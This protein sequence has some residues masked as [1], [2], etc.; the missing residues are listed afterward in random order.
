MEHAP[1]AI[2]LNGLL[3][4]LNELRHCAPQSL[5]GAAAEALQVSLVAAGGALGAAGTARALG[6]AERP[7]LAAACAA[8]TGTLVPYAAACFDRVYAGGGAL[9]NAKA[10]AAA[11]TGENGAA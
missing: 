9:L 3:A 2:Y 5:R 6:E 8:L 7:V 11:L 1:L 4:A 10:V